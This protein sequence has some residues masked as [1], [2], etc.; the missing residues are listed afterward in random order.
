MKIKIPNGDKSRD[1]DFF[2]IDRTMRHG[3]YSAECEAYT[4]II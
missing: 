4:A 1:G 3:R 2:A